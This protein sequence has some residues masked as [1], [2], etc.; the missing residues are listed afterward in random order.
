MLDEVE[1]VSTSVPVPFATEDEA[2]AQVAGLLAPAGLATAQVSA[3]DELNPLAGVTV[4]VEVSEVVA[5]AAM[6]MLPLLVNMKLGT[7]AEVTVTLTVVLDVSVPMV[8]V[9]VIA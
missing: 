2:S 7:A 9:T 4:I 6:V 5:P 3:T 1:T 8:P